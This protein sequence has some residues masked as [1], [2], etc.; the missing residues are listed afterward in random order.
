[1]DRCLDPFFVPD[2]AGETAGLA[3]RFGDLGGDLLQLFNAAP[4][5]RHLG[6]E[7]DELMRGATA[8]TAAAARHDH[9]LSIEHARSEHGP[10]GHAVSPSSQLSLL[11][12]T[13][14]RAPF[15]RTLGALYVNVKLATLGESG[16]RKWILRPSPTACANAF[17]ASRAST[18]P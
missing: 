17:R 8:D 3:V 13:P 18:R 2:V 12:R 6:A 9:D 14:E 10:V 7:S 1:A 15:D 16:R 11:R 5:Q 4:H